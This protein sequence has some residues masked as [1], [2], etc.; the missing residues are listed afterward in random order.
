MK[1]PLYWGTVHSFANT[2]TDSTPSKFHS[3]SYNGYHTHMYWDARTQYYGWNTKPNYV[4]DVR[5]TDGITFQ[6]SVNPRDF[7]D[8]NE[9]QRIA[10]KHAIPVFRTPSIFRTWIKTFQINGPGP[11]SLGGGNS[12]TKTANVNTGAS[13]GYF[14]SGTMEEWWMHEAAHGTI[15]PK[16]YGSAG[17]ARAVR[18]DNAYISTYA[19][20]FPQREDVAESIL[21]WMFARLYPTDVESRKIIRQIP[22]RLAFFDGRFPEIL[23]ELKLRKPVVRPP[24]DSSDFVTVECVQDTSSPNRGDFQIQAWWDDGQVNGWQKWVTKL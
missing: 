10:R 21:A 6:I 5:G 7:P 14:S 1:V 3:L 16:V 20:D 15:D 23:Q 19:K 2:I 4:F 18:Q 13:D 12:H 24:P 22:N 9:A 8:V 11:G 17:W